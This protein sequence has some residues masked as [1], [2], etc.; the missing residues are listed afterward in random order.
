MFK[1]LCVFNF[2][3]MNS[4]YVPRELSPVGLANE[5]P[6]FSVRYD[7]NLC[8]KHRFI[9]VFEVLYCVTLTQ[10][11]EELLLKSNETPT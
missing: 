10:V 2:L 4:K 8:T 5:K 11:F 7:L 3:K 9:S 6:V 1:Y